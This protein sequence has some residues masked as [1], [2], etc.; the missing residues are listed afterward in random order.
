MS[1]HSTL[2]KLDSIPKI[3]L[4]VLGI[5]FAGYGLVCLLFPQIVGLITS[6]SAEGAAARIE[7]Q[8]MYG[9]LQLGLG[10]WALLCAVRQDFQN[11]G[12]IS[13]VCLMGGLVFGRVYGLIVEPNA[14]AY[15]WGA[16]FFEAIAILALLASLAVNARKKARHSLLHQTEHS[17]S[18]A[19]GTP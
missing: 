7:T 16:L 19:I 17:Q 1:E 14:G 6:L 5:I 13:L 11:I 4:F 3:V 9:G 15:I 18:E 10:I 8:A 2:E 12:L